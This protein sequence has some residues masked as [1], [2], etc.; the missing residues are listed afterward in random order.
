MTFDEVERLHQAIKDSLNA[1]IAIYDRARDA[2]WPDP[3][4]ALHTWS[5]PRKE[6]EPCPRYS[7]PFTALRIRGRGTFCCPSCQPYSTA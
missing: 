3:P 4:S 1:A 7:T 2:E 5:I 6:G